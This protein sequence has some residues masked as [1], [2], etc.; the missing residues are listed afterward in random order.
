MPKLEI[1]S[2]AR[3]STF[4]YPEP[5]QIEKEKK[6]EEIE[7]AVLNVTAKQQKR[8]ETEKI[9]TTNSE[10]MEV[11][12]PTTLNEKAEIELDFSILK[13]PARVMPSQ[14]KVIELLQ[15]DKSGESSKY[16]PIKGIE[17]GGILVVRDCQPNKSSDIVGTGKPPLLKDDKTDDD[18]NDHFVEPETPEPF[19]I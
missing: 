19:F 2:K 5:I 6:K 15:I 4:A 10:Q 8:K 11:D 1:K 14:L 18:N 17:H 3:P 16:N 9:T 13:N 7:T 12:N